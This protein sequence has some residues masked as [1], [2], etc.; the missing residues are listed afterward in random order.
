[1]SLY[2]ITF[3]RRQAPSKEERKEFF[4]LMTAAGVPTAAGSSFGHVL[5][6]TYV[7]ES[8]FSAIKIGEMLMPHFPDPKDRLLVVQVHPLDSALCGAAQLG[9]LQLLQPCQ[10][11]PE[12]SANP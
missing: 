10:L 4:Q 12:R 7:L 8:R 9:A 2:V 5:G 6:S 11:C 3:T 1:M